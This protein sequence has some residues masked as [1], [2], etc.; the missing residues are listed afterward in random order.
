[1]KKTFVKNLLWFLLLFVAWIL[2]CFEMKI[3]KETYVYFSAFCLSVVLIFFSKKKW[4]SIVGVT[5]I[6][7]ATAIFSFKYLF[8]VLPVVLL[9]FAHREAT[10]NKSA[11]GLSQAFSTLSLML[12]AGQVILGFV[13]YSAENVHKVQ[14]IFLAFK[15]MIFF[16]GL[17][18]LLLVSASEKK[19]GKSDKKE[20]EKKLA[21]K[22]VYSVSLAGALVSVWSFYS[23]YSYEIQSPQTEFI[24]WFLYVVAM[25]ANKDPYIEVFLQKLSEK[26]EKFLSG[27][28]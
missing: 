1:M 14:N 10:Q 17:F 26:T 27:A 16:M 21:L 6:S 12:F 15:V 8:L 2:P 9:V 25:T 18:S 19:Q 22:M 23:L 20:K 28:K 11:E 13:S 3:F 7:A 4:L 24:F 5:V